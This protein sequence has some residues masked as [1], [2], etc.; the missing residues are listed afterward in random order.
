MYHQRQ[1]YVSKDYNCNDKSKSLKTAPNAISMSLKTTHPQ[2]DKH[3]SKDYPPHL[4]K[5]VS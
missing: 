4:D 3:V 5:H 2:S 1:K